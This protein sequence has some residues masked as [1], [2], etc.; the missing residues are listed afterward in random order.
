MNSGNDFLKQLVTEVMNI[1]EEGTKD[2][3]RMVWSW[4]IDFL[5]HHWLLS[6]GILFLVFTFVSLK[7]LLGRWGSLYSFTYNCLYFGTLFVVGLIAGPEI[8]LNDIFNAICAIVLYPVCYY[9]VGYIW[10]YTPFGRNAGR[11]RRVNFR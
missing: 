5:A 4:L 2:G 6:I 7:A 1:F 10:D 8:F 11:P 9:L 3:V